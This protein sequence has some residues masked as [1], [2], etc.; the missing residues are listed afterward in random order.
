MRIPYKIIVGMF[1]SN[2]TFSYL[3]Q[4]YK[5]ATNWKVKF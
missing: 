1:S 4:R 5:L 3:F 2:N